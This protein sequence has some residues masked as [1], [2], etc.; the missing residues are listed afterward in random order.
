M[1]QGKIL[2][3]LIAFT[4]ASMILVVSGDEESTGVGKRADW[5]ISISFEGDPELRDAMTQA[6][7]TLGAFIERLPELR[8]G[9]AGTSIKFPLTEND[10][11]EHVWMSDVQFDGE[12]FTGYLASEPLRLAGWSFGD[13]VTVPA[14]EILDW[15]AIEDRTLYGGFSIY[16]LNA[17]ASPQDVRLQDAHRGFSLPDRPIVWD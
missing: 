13:R 5:N 6:R 10:V 3:A 11:I 12:H 4:F 2:M 8:A 15:A 7:A 14:D 17:R 9:G 16:V 1:S